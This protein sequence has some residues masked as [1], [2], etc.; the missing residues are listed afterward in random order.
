MTTS[1]SIDFSLTRDEIISDALEL[2]GA[3]GIGETPTAADLTTCSRSLNMMVKA[4][5][6]QGIHLWTKTTLQVSLVENQINY[7]LSPRPLMILQAWLR[8][9]DNVDRPIM[10]DN[11]TSYNMIPN[12]TTSGKINRIIYDPQLS[13]GILSVWPVPDDDTDVLYLKYIRV[14][15]DFDSSSNTPD[16]PQEWLQPLVE[17]LAVKVAPKYG[18]VLS[19][20]NPDIISNAATSLAEMRMWD[21]ENAKIR[22]VPAADY[23]N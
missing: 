21:V 18:K 17:N 12:K 23:G 20:T 15:E 5:E 11:M 22:V 3:I 4:W 1:S 10:I 9:T 16:L 2:I 13:T 14:I 7:T 19:K 8:N 6:A